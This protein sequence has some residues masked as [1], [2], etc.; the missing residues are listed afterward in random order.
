M[1]HNN[2]ITH[3]H[4]RNTT[5]E[6][7]P[8]WKVPWN[9]H[10]YRTQWLMDQISI[11]GCFQLLSSSKFQSCLN[12]V[13]NVGNTFVNLSFAL[14]DGFA[15]LHGHSLGEHLLSFVHELLEL[16]HFLETWLKAIVS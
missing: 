3:H 15:H 5:L 9:Y 16:P 1:L 7:H 8:K 10:H 2:R 11:L 13:I 12:V 6:W 14:I 4:G